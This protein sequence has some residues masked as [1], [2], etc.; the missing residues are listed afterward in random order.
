MWY[1]DNV[2]KRFEETI[3]RAPWLWVGWGMFRLISDCLRSE[4]SKF[5]YKRKDLLKEFFNQYISEYNPSED[6][7]G[8][9][10]GDEEGDDEKDEGDDGKKS[11]LL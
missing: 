2:P 7:D 11:V 10:N 8:E 4:I 6:L 3:G 5:I 9:E 1:G